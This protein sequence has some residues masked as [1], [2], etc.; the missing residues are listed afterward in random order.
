M[1]KQDDADVKTFVELPGLREIFE[2]LRLGRHI[3]QP[4]GR[5][6]NQ[7]NENY[8]AYNALF[9]QL[10]F[11]LKKHRR[12]F[13][14]FHSPNSMSGQSEK[15]AVFM[16]ILIEHI[17]DKGHNIEETLMNQQFAYNQLPHL[18]NARYK[19]IMNQLDV[20]DEDGL[21]DIV[22]N[23]DRTGFA[24]H[25]NDSSFAFRSPIYRF[26]DICQDISLKQKSDAAL[27]EEHK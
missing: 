23:M 13:Y 4:D 19:N 10:G 22:A 24:E 5:I 9:A 1:N 15:M 2:A 7:L 17:A 12:D 14:Y 18:K 25:L 16:F 11:D 8:D 6:Y 21:I 26:L 20:L 3:C 27:T